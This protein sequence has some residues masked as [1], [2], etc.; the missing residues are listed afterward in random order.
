VKFADY[1]FR[2][3]TLVLGEQDAKLMKLAATE[4]PKNNL[5]K[6][7]GCFAEFSPVNSFRISESISKTSPIDVELGRIDAP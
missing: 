2:I 7:L 3:A 4:R 6:N 1:S 5:R